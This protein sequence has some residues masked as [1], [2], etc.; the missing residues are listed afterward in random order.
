MGRRFGKFAYRSVTERQRSNNRYILVQGII[1]RLCDFSH[2]NN[3]LSMIIYNHPSSKA[4]V[5]G[6]DHSVFDTTTMCKRLMGKIRFDDRG[7]L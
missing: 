4:V 5:S 1:I 7:I 2:D 6:R 3:I